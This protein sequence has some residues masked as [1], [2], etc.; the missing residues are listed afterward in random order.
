VLG[1]THPINIGPRSIEIFSRRSRQMYHS[2][3][4]AYLSGN[5]PLSCTATEAGV[6]CAAVHHLYDETPARID[7]AMERAP[8]HGAPYAAPATRAQPVHATSSS[9]RHHHRAPARPIS[10]TPPRAHGHLHQP[11]FRRGPLPFFHHHPS[12]SAA[13][14]RAASSTR[15]TTSCSGG[16]AC[17]S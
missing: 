6:Q 14:R 17:S 5:H 7:A 1:R 3:T 13:G 9:P 12:S 8:P 4:R 2:A 15:A 10:P 11:P 16:T